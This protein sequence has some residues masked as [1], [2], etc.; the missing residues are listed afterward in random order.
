MT[1]HCINLLLLFIHLSV[2]PYHH[3]SKSP[4]ENP[5]ISI[6]WA[7][8][9]C[10]FFLHPSI[11]LSVYLPICQSR[12]HRS[13]KSINCQSFKPSYQSIYQP[14]CKSLFLF[15]IYL[16]IHPSIIHPT[17]HP[18]IHPLI[19]PTYLSNRSACLSPS[20]LDLPIYQWIDL[21]VFHLPIDLS[22]IYLSI[23]VHHCKPLFGNLSIYKESFFLVCLGNF[24]I[25]SHLLS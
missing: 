14:I 21:L 6:R 18:S 15:A 22:I 3:L 10:T 13:N 16:S 12:S 24:P 25:F 23:A 11:F 5:F 19:C 8:Y 4:C 17:I 20:Y 9:S 7:I 2:T 1:K